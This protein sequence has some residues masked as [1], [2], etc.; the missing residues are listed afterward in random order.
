MS[1]SFVVVAIS[2]TDAIEQ[3]LSKLEE[4][5]VNQPVHKADIE[6]AKDTVKAFVALLRE[7]ES[8]PAEGENEDV[9]VTLSVSGSIWNT[10]AGA[11]QVS[12]SINGSVTT[13]R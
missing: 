12:F 3:A 5:V 9:S 2:K 1:Y 10:D 4:V 13:K 6:Q 11:N 8:G 7:P